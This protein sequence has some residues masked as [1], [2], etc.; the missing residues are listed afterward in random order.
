MRN[1]LPTMTYERE[2]LRKAGKKIQSARKAESAAMDAA[3]TAAINAA[4]ANIPETTIASEL[5]VDRMT[6]RK[7]LG[8]R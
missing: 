7:W 3:M 4:A 1:M 6:V 8:K 5:G 2:Q